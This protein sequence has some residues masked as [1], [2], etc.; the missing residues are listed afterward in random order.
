MVGTQSATV[1]QFKTALDDIYGRSEELMDSLSAEDWQRKHGADWTMSDVPFHIAYFD[2]EL[3]KKPLEAGENL[4]EGDRVVF[5]SLESI[6]AWNAAE[7]AKRSAGQTIEETREQLASARSSIRAH[8]D[9]MSEA[10]LEARVWMALG[11]FEWRPARVALSGCLLHNWNEHIQLSLRLGRTRFMPAAETTHIALDTML[12][13][14]P[15]GMNREAAA[16]P[17]AVRFAISGPGGG[18]WLLQA[19]EGECEVSEDGTSP[20]DITMRMSSENFVRMTGQMSNP[21]MMMLTRKLRVSG[22]FKMP[23]FGK[24]F[25]PPG[26]DTQFQGDLVKL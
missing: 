16:E 24:V 3:V 5:D 23:T 7:F 6:D 10:D 25:P 9:A 26:G 20:A 22:L 17:F 19:A 1:A 14:M 4:A 18:E 15:M 13:I 21:M 8:V 11:G 12:R 2:R